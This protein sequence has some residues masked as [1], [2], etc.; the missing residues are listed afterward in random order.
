VGLILI[1]NE[2][3]NVMLSGGAQSR[4]HFEAVILHKLSTELEDTETLTL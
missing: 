4:P 1:V 3:L 2:L